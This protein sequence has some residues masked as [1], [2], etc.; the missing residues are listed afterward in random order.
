MH[1]AQEQVRQFHREVA[2]SPTSPAEPALRN[3]V[4]RARLILEEAIETVVG[5]IGARIAAEAVLE[6]MHQFAAKHGD[7]QARPD[8]V[9]AIDGCIDLLV[10]AYGTLEDIGVDAEPFF[11]E[12][13]RA[14]MAKKNG[15]V[16]AD[17]KL[18]KPPGWTPPDIAGVLATMRR[19]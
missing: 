7:G 19:G 14:N 15:P 11:D 3:T 5:L 13:M 4:L 16:R 18:Q 17:G 1:K 12:V 2:N 6:A 8:L 10:I 9:E